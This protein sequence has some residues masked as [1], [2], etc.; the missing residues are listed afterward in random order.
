MRRATQMS[1]ALRFA[2][3]VP[4]FPTLDQRIDL[5]L[6]ETHR[7]SAPRWL[8]PL[9]VRLRR[10]PCTRRAILPSRRCSTG[11]PLTRTP[12]RLRLRIRVRP[13]LEGPFQ[14]R[15]LDHPGRVEGN[16]RLVREGVADQVA[17]LNG[18]PGKDLAVGGAGLASTLS[19]LRL[20]DEYA[21]NGAQI[22]RPVPRCGASTSWSA[23][24]SNE[25][26][27]VTQARVQGA[28]RL[29]VDG[30]LRA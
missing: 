6:V 1:C 27:K 15:L 8:P 17:R 24:A 19:K 12:C 25:A 20:I 10:C 13:H 14:D 23:H 26:A 7:R 2:P 30:G 9:P 5:D 16:A 18:Q 29:R 11:R 4:Y 22:P 28:N 3:N 21:E